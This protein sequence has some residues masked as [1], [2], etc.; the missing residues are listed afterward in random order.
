M[1]TRPK[2][3]PSR[4]VGSREELEALLVEGLESG[5]PRPMTEADWEALR[6]RALAG[7]E[8]RKSS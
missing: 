1:P 8:L 6:K 2:Y 5:E 7:V 3:H 4:P